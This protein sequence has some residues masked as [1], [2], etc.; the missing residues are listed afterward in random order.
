MS[1][2]KLIQLNDNPGLN[3]D[4]LI[5]L[6]TDYESGQWEGSGSAVGFNGIHLLVYNLSHC[7]C[8]GP[9]EGGPESMSLE[10]YFKNR[11]SATF[12]ITGQVFKEVG[13]YLKS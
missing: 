8:Y 3:E 9:N 11:E 7:S 5:W 12:E 6:V 10:T 2:C 13:L 4:G 1:K